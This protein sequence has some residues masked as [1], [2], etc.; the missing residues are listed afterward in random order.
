MVSEPRTAS[1]GHTNNPNSFTARLKNN[2]RF[3][4]LPTL[5]LLSFTLGLIGFSTYFSNPEVQEALG[6]HSKLD[7]I[8]LT[9]QLF[10]LESGYVDVRFSIPPTLEF[11]RAFAPVVSAWAAIEM[12]ML[13][14]RERW[15]RIRMSIQKDHVV[16][17]GLGRKGF[18]VV[19]DCLDDDDTVIVIEQ[20]EECHR[21]AMC[22]ER[23]AYVIVG[24]ATSDSILEKARARYAKEVIAFCGNDG[25][26]VSIA[27]NIRDLMARYGHGRGEGHQTRCHVQVVDFDFCNQFRQHPIF[28]LHDE[29]LV[30]SIFNIYENAARLLL[31]EHPLER[32]CVLKDDPRVVHL[33]LLG[34]GQ[35]GESLLIQAA[36]LAHFA[37]RKKLK[38]TVY[39]TFADDRQKSF[40]GRYKNIDKIMDLTFVQGDVEYDDVLEEVAANVINPDSL[41]SVVVSLDTDSHTLTAAI[42]IKRRVPETDT[43]IYVHLVEDSGLSVLFQRESDHDPNRMQPFGMTSTV[44]RRTMLDHHDIDFLAERI[45]QEHVA[46]KLREG[47]PAE[48]STQ[49][50]DCLA[51]DFKDS[52]RQ[53]ADHIPVKLRG[54]GYGIR[55]VVDPDGPLH[56][57]QPDEI[58]TMAIAEH[59]RWNADRYLAGWEFAPPPKNEKLRT[60]PC[61]VEWEELSNDIQEYDREPVRN[62]PQLLRLIG[63]EVY[64][65]SDEARALPLKGMLLKAD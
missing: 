43:P 41:T 32:V 54:V 39:D 63:K 38:V 60:H 11:A 55:N 20:D 45:H 53:Q 25:I 62:I 61:L 1:A 18:Q 17:C 22:K 42:G 59:D 7:I 9:W 8:Y 36:K 2:W 13:F 31:S 37:N 52:N 58:E 46:Q 14:L 30:V 12:L 16:V 3:V 23:G 51:Y 24:D 5:G 65:L 21:I 10:T 15:R 57:F 28:A 19:Q 34:L 6:T 26:N 47:K 27:L 29:P 49:P 4:A 40:S 48:P 50:W 64:E 35:M 56:E 33:M 44:C